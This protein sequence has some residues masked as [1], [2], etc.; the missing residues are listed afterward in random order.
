MPESVLAQKY[1]N[2]EVVVI[3]NASTDGTIDIWSSSK[4]AAKS[5]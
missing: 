1:P 4:I 2:K 3:D 5:Y